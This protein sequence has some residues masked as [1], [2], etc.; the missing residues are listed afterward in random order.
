MSCKKLQLEYFLKLSVIR[1]QPLAKNISFPAKLRMSPRMPLQNKGLKH[2]V[3]ATLRLSQ[4]C[5]LRKSANSATLRLSQNLCQSEKSV[6]KTGSISL[7][8]KTVFNG[9]NVKFWK[10]ATRDKQISP[11]SWDLSKK[12]DPKKIYIEGIST[13]SNV[14]DVK[15]IG[16]HKLKGNIF[17]TKLLKV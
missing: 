10:K 8:K 16:C 12:S 5:E 2:I 6:T 4:I 11:L 1:C 15:L 17:Y 9:G 14:K 13:S 3:F 7:I